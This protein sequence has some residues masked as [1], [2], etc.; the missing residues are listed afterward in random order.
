VNEKPEKAS[1]AWGDVL[2]MVIGWPGES[3]PCAVVGNVKL[4]V[5]SEADPRPQ[6]I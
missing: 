1:E 4:E 2:T 6:L 5:L 3:V